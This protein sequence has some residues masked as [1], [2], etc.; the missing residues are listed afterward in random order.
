MLGL[1]GGA[2]PTYQV[3]TS[4]KVREALAINPVPMMSG[5]METGVSS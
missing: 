3:A 1:V 4:T 5:M 2:T